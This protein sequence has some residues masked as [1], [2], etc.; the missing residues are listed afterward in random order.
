VMFILI[1]E[2]VK[3]QICRVS[4]N[5]ICRNYCSADALEGWQA[6]AKNVKYRRS[7]KS[8]IGKPVLFCGETAEKEKNLQMLLHFPKKPV[9]IEWY[10][11][12][13]YCA[14]SIAFGKIL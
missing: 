14:E 10:D 7:Q 1:I 12:V 6:A 8:G 11:A 9:I 3:N 4:Q 13:R 5:E 2:N